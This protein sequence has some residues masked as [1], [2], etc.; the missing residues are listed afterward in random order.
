ME[1]RAG[2][3]LTGR[4]KKEERIIPI[5]KQDYTPRSVLIAPPIIF[6]TRKSK[7][8]T[9]KM[10]YSSTFIEQQYKRM[11]TSKCEAPYRCEDELLAK[12][13]LIMSCPGSNI[14]TTSFGIESTEFQGATGYAD[15]LFSLT[16]AR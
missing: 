10:N 3:R 2:P 4:L 15:F 13:E 6:Q 12:P 7:L 14:N 1:M 9:C 16:G 11:Q 5:D 8:S